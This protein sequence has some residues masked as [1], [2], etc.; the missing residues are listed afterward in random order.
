MASRMQS[1][2]E[3]LRAGEIDFG[4]FE[5]RTRDDWRRLAR[6]MRGRWRVPPSLDSEDVR[7]VMLLAA[8]HA[9]Q[10]WDPTRGV[11]IHRHVVWRALDKAQKEIH[12]AR[13]AL[14]WDG[15]APSRSALVVSPVTEDGEP[16][17]R[18]AAEP[19]Q[20]AASELLLWARRNPADARLADLLAECCGDVDAAARLLL[21]DYRLR[22]ATGIEN[23]RAARAAF[24]RVLGTLA[25]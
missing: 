3:A 6:H 2:C 18:R 13:G 20:D 25:A 19:G 4:E 17:D 9:A 12:R 14:R 16:R 11:A 10:Q 23:Y 15:K 8:W 22:L 7:Q 21:S 5:R 24:R 1:A